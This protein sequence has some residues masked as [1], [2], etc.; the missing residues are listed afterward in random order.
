MIKHR[1][2]LEFY[3]TPWQQFGLIFYFAFWTLVF[4]RNMNPN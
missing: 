1:I 4:S 2:N 3:G